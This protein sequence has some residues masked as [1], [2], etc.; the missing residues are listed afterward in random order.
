[1]TKY[2]QKTITVTL[3]NGT[4]KRLKAYGKTEKEALMKL[5]ELKT[6]YENGLI[7]LTGKS[8]FAAYAEKWLA[9]Y[10][11]PNVAETTL[12]NDQRRLNRYILPRIGNL[13]LDKITSS[14]IQDC[15]LAIKQDNLSQDY[16][17]KSYNLVYNILDQARKD[18]LIM[19]NNAENCTLYKCKQP[20][21]RRELTETE[22][23]LFLAACELLSPQTACRYLIS[24][25]CGLRPAETRA[26]KFSNW[27]TKTN[28]ITITNSINA[29]G[30]LTAPK[31]Q[32]GYRTIPIP[33]NLQKK[34]IQMPRSINPNH[35]LFGD[36]EKPC[37]KQRYERGWNRIVREMNILAGAE[38]YRN[39]IIT[40]MVDSTLTPYYLR[41]TYCTMLAENGMPIKT[42]QYLM[43]HSTIDMTS[44]VYTH[45]NKKILS[46]TEDILRAL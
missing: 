12:K 3:P 17:K 8:T 46:N 22:R 2:I 19:Y 21:T 44:G 14:D 9:S 40:P 23:E 1:M 31:S 34:L 33:R 45:V 16:M 29:K 28:E 25:Y 27:N 39:Q 37:T 30:E 36:G 41:H 5:S 43:G 15:L 10:K 20:T 26:L 42:A 6:K 11:A 38:L 24:Y 4:K 13:P 32:A 35:F 7:I 18:R